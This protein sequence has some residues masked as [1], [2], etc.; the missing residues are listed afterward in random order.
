MN[1]CPSP[2]NSIGSD[3]RLVW[4]TSDYI[5]AHYVAVGCPQ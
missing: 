4:P 2:L 3:S 5:T 1:E